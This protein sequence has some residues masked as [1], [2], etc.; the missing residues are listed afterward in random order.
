MARSLYLRLALALAAA[1]PTSLLY[2]STVIDLPFHLLTTAGGGYGDEVATVVV[3]DVLYVA[4]AVYAMAGLMAWTWLAGNRALAR[5][6]FTLP[7]LA[8]LGRPLTVFFLALLPAVLVAAQVVQDAGRYHALVVDHEV[9]LEAL[10]FVWFGV[11]LQVQ[12]YAFEL[13][14]DRQRYTRKLYFLYT[15][16]PTPTPTPSSSA[17]TTTAPGDTAAMVGDE[18]A[19]ENMAKKKAYELSMDPTYAGF[20][21]S[22]MSINDFNANAFVREGAIAVI[23]VVDPFAFPQGVGHDEMTLWLSEEATL[24]VSESA[25]VG[26]RKN[27]VYTPEGTRRIAFLRVKFSVYAVLPQNAATLPPPPADIPRY[28]DEWLSQFGASRLLPL[29]VGES[30]EEF[31]RWQTE[32]GH[33]IGGAVVNPNAKSPLVRKRINEPYMGWFDFLRWLDTC[34]DPQCARYH[35]YEVEK[36]RERPS[37]LVPRFV[38]Y[39][40][41][42]LA[43]SHG[44]RQLERRYEIFSG[45]FNRRLASTSLATIA[46]CLAVFLPLR[47]HYYPAINQVAFFAAFTGVGCLLYVAWA[48]VAERLHRHGAAAAVGAGGAKG[49]E[50]KGLRVEGLTVPTTDDGAALLPH[51]DRVGLNDVSQASPS[52]GTV[53]PAK[54]HFHTNVAHYHQ[55]VRDKG[56]GHHTDGDTEMDPASA[57]AN[58]Y[59]PLPDSAPL[60]RVPYTCPLFDIVK[61]LDDPTYL[62][63][64]EGDLLFD[65]DYEQNDVMLPPVFGGE[66]DRVRWQPEG[67]DE[68]Y[69]VHFGSSKAKET[70]PGQLS[71]ELLIVN[72]T[73]EFQAET[74]VPYFCIW[75]E[76]FLHKHLK[77][78]PIV[79]VT[80]PGT[81]LPLP[82]Q[83]S[84][85]KERAERQLE[86]SGSSGAGALVDARTDEDRQDEE[87]AAALMRLFASFKPGLPIP[88]ELLDHDTALV[89]KLIQ[90]EIVVSEGY[91]RKRAAYFKQQNERARHELRTVGYTILRNLL[92]KRHL[93]FLRRYY[94]RLFQALGGQPA[95][96]KY[97]MQKTQW[98]DEPSSRFI[99]HYLTG[100]MHDLVQEPV[101]H[102]GL[103]L[104]IW[105]LKGHGFPLHRDSVPPFD[106]TLDFVLDH[107]GPQPRP[108]TFIRRRRGALGSLLPGVEE[109]TLSLSVGEAVLFRGSEMP[110]FGGDLGEGNYHNVL[111]WTWSYVRD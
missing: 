34:S 105:I 57:V 104:S 89:Q 85:A 108:V 91:W 26:P 63:G 20:T 65:E 21:K 51:S 49:T 76:E 8:S 16:T 82:Y 39:V 75:T 80:M 101:L 84:S 35:R 62:F 50:E 4:C 106:L 30:D 67:K 92:P 15:P 12:L 86:A 43:A 103:A 109:M 38:D 79:M 100:M 90:S 29:C 52:G 99:N 74:T 46:A 42:F 25:D 1:V 81:G 72:P 59:S 6:F 19:E 66:K 77:G 53:L 9:S 31:R 27:I 41:W 40:W 102:P 11:A 3:D 93:H 32:L 69:A 83:L 17:S 48:V 61:G 54:Y 95:A 24:R 88:R 98:N 7:R 58:P 47:L 110:H 45:R 96:D 37:S 71:D 2:L 87:R 10:L 56:E 64:G 5:H 28:I 60:L 13:G 18:A 22:V 73:F 36:L 44:P 14:Q 55:E 107:V 70:S 78:E 97:Q 23:F 68:D 33:T 94:R 111:L